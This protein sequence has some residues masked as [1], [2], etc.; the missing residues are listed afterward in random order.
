MLLSNP[1]F[2]FTIIS[3]CAAREAL[4]SLPRLDMDEYV[5]FLSESMIH[6]DPAK[7][8]KQKALEERITAPF[9]LR[10]E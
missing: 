6:A 8:A 9:R 2:D 10:P 5:A 3:K 7:A 1:R 4:R